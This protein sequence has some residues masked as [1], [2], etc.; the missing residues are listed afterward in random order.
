MKVG[1]YYVHLT[2]LREDQQ[3]CGSVVHGCFS[4]RDEWAGETDDPIAIVGNAVEADRHRL[5]SVVT[6]SK[7]NVFMER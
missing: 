3:N 1:K 5:R 2:K 4:A 7:Q 6:E